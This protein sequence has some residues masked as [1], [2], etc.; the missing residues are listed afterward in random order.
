MSGDNRGGDLVSEALLRAIALPLERAG[1]LQSLC[2]QR[3]VYSQLAGA[4]PA[5]RC[6]WLTSTL[7]HTLD[8]LDPGHAVPRNNFV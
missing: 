5:P 3:R 4:D 6:V 2:A 8:G 7:S 1:S